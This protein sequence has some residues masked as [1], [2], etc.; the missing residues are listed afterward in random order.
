MKKQMSYV[1]AKEGAE[2]RSIEIDPETALKDIQFKIDTLIDSEWQLLYNKSTT[3]QEYK[4]LE[5]TVSR[6]IKINLKNRRKE[7]LITRL[8][9]GK[10]RLNAYL[11]KLKKHPTGNCDICNQPETVEHFLLHC[12]HQT[13]SSTQEYQQQKKLWQQKTLTES[14]TEQLRSN[15]G[16]KI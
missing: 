2:K 11:Y 9:L 15:E 13:F 3:G 7:I 1:L 14:T 6:T 5:P 16:C 12:Q 10:C 4:K 8:R